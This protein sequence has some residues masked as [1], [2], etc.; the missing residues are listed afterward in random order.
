MGSFRIFIWSYLVLK[1]HGNIIFFLW[2][3]GEKGQAAFPPL[4]L[5]R[6]TEGVEK[7]SRKDD[8][9]RAGEG[10]PLGRNGGGGFSTSA[11]TWPNTS[12]ANS[13]IYS[14]VFLRDRP[15]FLG[16]VME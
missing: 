1:N 2:A 5:L 15:I 16:S 12:I 3:G 8:R 7:R 4:V 9:K 14:A 13:K 10:R 6:G 11:G